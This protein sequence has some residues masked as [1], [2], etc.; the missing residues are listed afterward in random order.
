MQ[1]QLNDLLNNQEILN[2]QQRAHQD[3]ISQLKTLEN[4]LDDIQHSK[5]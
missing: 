1:K 3:K 4:G 2:Q 5:T